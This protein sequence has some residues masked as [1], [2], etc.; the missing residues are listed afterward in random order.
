MSTER[1]PLLQEIL[2]PDAHQAESPSITRKPFGPRYAAV[3][4]FLFKLCFFISATTAVEI[5]QELV[6]RLYWNYH[7]TT[8]PLPGDRCADPSVRRYFAMLQSLVVVMEGLG[9]IVMYGPMSRLSGKYGRRSM[10]MILTVVLILGTLCLIGAYR[11][12]MVFTAPLLL[13]WLVLASIAGQWQF[14]LMTVMYVVDTTTSEERTSGLSFVLGWA[15]IAGIPGFAIGGA[16]TT[17]LGSNTAVYWA[18]IGIALVLLAYIAFILPES[19]DSTRRAKLQQQ[20][21]NER[22][23]GYAKSSFDTFLRPLLLLKPRRDPAT[24]FLNLRLLWCGIH[25]FF[26]GLASG[27]LWTAFV[28]Y[29]AL[30][31]HYRPDDSGYI[32]SAG[33]ISSG[34]SLVV[35]TPLAIKLLSPFYNTRSANDVETPNSEASSSGSSKMDKHLAIFGWM[36][37][38]MAIALLPLARTRGQVAICVVTLG[39]SYFRLSAFRSVVAASGDPLRSGE[40]LSAIQTITSFGNVISGLVL[41]S[42]LTASINTF[43]GLV[44]LVY[45]AIASVSVIAL[46]LIRESDRYIPPHSSESS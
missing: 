40:I 31:L 39:G 43:P 15:Y 8:F 35:I 24:G 44:F 36:V 41:G 12:P 5:L 2:E 33:A 6:C 4:A 3:I 14:D 9:G 32:L 26:S 22:A 46:C 25:A 19:F 18:V 21:Q 13:S 17:Y 20:W 34:G 11:L 29:V 37:D 10:L 7:D 28:V 27:Y 1:D 45:S 42:V 16:L 30:H 23:A 38:I